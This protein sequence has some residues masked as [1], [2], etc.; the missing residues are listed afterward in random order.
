MKNRTPG[1][2]DYSIDRSE[3]QSKKGII[4]GKERKIPSPRMAI[5]DP[6]VYS[7]LM[8]LKS[9]CKYSFS[10][11]KKFLDDLRIETLK[12]KMPG[13][14]D[15]ENFKTARKIRGGKFFKSANDK[16]PTNTPGPGVN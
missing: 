5:P 9:S 11:Q 13:P 2:G 3:S 12:A 15:Y 16:S 4:F 7:S 14:G 6:G 10:K 8:L 1:P